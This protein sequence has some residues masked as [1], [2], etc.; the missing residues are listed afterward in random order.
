MSNA[1]KCDKCGDFEEGTPHRYEVGKYKKV[2]PFSGWSDKDTIK[3][4]EICSNC[5]EKFT[6]FVKQ[7]FD[8]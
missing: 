4:V 2:S 3:R 1:Y 6:S 5:E 8:E 7:F